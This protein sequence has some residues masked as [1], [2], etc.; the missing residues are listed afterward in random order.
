MKHLEPIKPSRNEQESRRVRSGQASPLKLLLISALLV[1][2]LGYAIDDAWISGAVDKVSS[3][4]QAE[5]E[6]TFAKIQ[7]VELVPVSDSDTEAALATMRLPP[8]Q[9]QQLMSELSKRVDLAPDANPAASGLRLVWVTLWDFAA[10]D[11]DVV[12]VASAGYQSDV[13]LQ[14]KPTRIAVPLDGTKSVK[15]TGVHDGGGGITLGVESGGNP[16]ALPLLKPGVSLVLPA[17]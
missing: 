3:T 6:T 16:L 8:E 7:S 15:I 17:S 2:G 5:L 9:R 13:V 12:N 1:A 14:K 10:A 11:G 4:H